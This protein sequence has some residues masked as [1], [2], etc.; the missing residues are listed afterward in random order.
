M[1]KEELKEEQCEKLSESDI[2]H[3]AKFFDLLAKL[4]H[5]DKKLARLYKKAE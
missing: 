1:E 2:D 3:L 4:D 5:E